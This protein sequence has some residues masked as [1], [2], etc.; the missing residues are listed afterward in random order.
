MDASGLVRSQITM[1]I[2]PTRSGLWTV[3]S[4]TDALYHWRE[5]WTSFVSPTLMRKRHTCRPSETVI[6]TIEARVRQLAS[7]PIHSSGQRA[8]VHCDAGGYG[9]AVVLV[10]GVPIEERQAARVENGHLQLGTDG[11]KCLTCIQAGDEAPVQESKPVLTERTRVLSVW[12]SEAVGIGRS[13]TLRTRGPHIIRGNI[14]GDDTSREEI[15]T[16]VQWYS[17]TYAVFFGP[18]NEL[19][20]EILLFTEPVEMELD[21]PPDH[22][23]PSKGAR[24]SNAPSQRRAVPPETLEV[25][26][27]RC[28]RISPDIGYGAPLSPPRLSPRG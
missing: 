27:V 20:H 25:R 2:P 12:V 7:G 19:C 26:T 9:V 4:N 1:K 6:C 13:P 28:L 16:G 15:D 8:L 21:N 22:A 3:R 23:F 14:D 18:H 10:I 11:E 17:S 5:P 24:R